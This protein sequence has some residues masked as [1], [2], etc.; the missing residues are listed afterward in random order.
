MRP[1]IGVCPTGPR[2]RFSRPPEAARGAWEHRK[3]FTSR[4]ARADEE[5]AG[6][7]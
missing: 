5:R 7:G 4:E 1:S 3:R 6:D 2:C